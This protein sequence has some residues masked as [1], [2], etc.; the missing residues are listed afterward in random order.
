MRLLGMMIGLSALT[1]WG[2]GQL[3]APSRRCRRWHSGRTTVAAFLNRQLEYQAQQVTRITL[4]ILHQ[5]FAIAGVFCLLAILP[6]S[7]CWGGMM[8]IRNRARKGPHLGRCGFD[9]FSQF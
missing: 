5:T 8:G 6:R 4:D 2:S 7:S 9:P 3:D 1:S